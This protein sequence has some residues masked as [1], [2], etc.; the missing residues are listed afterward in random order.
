M[1]GIRKK[2]KSVVSNITLS[3]KKKT[4]VLITISCLDN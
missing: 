2:E 1:Y 4:S 3:S